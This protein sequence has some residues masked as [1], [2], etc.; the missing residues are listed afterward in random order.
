MVKCQRIDLLEQIE[1]G[2][3][4]FDIRVRFK[5]EKVISGHGIINYDVDVLQELEM[6]N[7]HSRE[8]KPLYVRIMYESK[9][10]CKNPTVEEMLVFMD[11]LKQNYPSLIFTQCHIRNPYTLVETITDVPKKDC[12]QFY[13]DYGAQ[14]FRH[15]LI[16]LKLPYPEYY[17]KRNNKKYFDELDN[18]VF[19]ILDFVDIK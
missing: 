10:F 8:E 15:K 9:P 12:Y 6:L 5:K 3:T 16:G 1:Y 11:K 14:T 7:T 4:Y 13:K 18:G 19:S 17:A 2:V